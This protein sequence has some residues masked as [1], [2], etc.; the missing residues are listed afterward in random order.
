[1]YFLIRE[2]LRKKICV[3]RGKRYPADGADRV[4]QMALIQ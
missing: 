4:P 1:V 2:N 3:I